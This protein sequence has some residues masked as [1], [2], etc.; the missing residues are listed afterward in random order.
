LLSDVGVD[1]DL[2][3]D[4]VGWKYVVNQIV[5]VFIYL[6]R[7]HHFKGAGGGLVQ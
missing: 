7:E 4:P 5:F 2:R 1:V 3:F 6:V